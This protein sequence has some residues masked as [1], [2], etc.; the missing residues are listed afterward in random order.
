MTLHNGMSL[1]DAERAALVLGCRIEQVTGTGERRLTGSRLHKP[2]TYNCRKR[3][4]P[5]ALVVALRRLG[6]AR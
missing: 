4:A 3:D 2:V 5:R 1:R 6:K